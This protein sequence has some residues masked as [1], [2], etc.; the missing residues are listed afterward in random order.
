MVPPL[1]LWLNQMAS[2]CV[3]VCFGVSPQFCESV[4]ARASV[5]MNV[6]V[7]C[8]SSSGLTGQA[9]FCGV[10]SERCVKTDWE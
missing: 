4:H 5:L 6:V 3:F 1:R 10:G 9:A 8:A 2:T 7:G